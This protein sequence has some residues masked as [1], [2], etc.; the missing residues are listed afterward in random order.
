MAEFKLV[1]SNP[2]DGKSYQRSISGVD[3]QNLV[4]MKLGDKVKGEAI[5]LQGYEFEITGGSDFAGFPMR[6]DLEGTL[7]T[8]ILTVSGVGVHRKRRGQRQRKTVVGNTI[9]EK[10][11]QLN[12]K[13]LKE[14]KSPLGGAP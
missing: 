4:G 5:D 13:V 9:H 10:I 12:L 1:L 8:K 6:K 3:A 14:G 7:K 11:I 2:K